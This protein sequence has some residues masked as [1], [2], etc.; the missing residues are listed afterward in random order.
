M[1]LP[2]PSDHRLPP[3]SHSDLE[4]GTPGAVGTVSLHGG[5]CGYGWLAPIL[6]CFVCVVC[7]LDLCRLSQTL[8][9]GR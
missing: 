6:V 4:S 2:V 1:A 8:Y 9:A 3:Q 7:V 5:I